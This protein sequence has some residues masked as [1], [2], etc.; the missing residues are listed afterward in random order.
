MQALIRTCSCHTV[1]DYSGRPV[2]AHDLVSSLISK[3]CCQARCLD[4]FQHLL[5]N[6]VVL[7][8]NVYS[9]TKLALHGIQLSHVAVSAA[10]KIS[11]VLK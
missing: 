2:E 6:A 11:Y 10:D 5:N 8:A 7:C 3:G 4:V 1:S 9:S